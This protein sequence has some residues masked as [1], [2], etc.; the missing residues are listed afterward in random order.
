MIQKETSIKVILPRDSY[1]YCSTMQLFP[2]EFSKITFHPGITQSVTVPQC[3]KE[4]HR[5]EKHTKENCSKEKL[6]Q[7][8][9]APR[10]NATRENAL[11]KNASSNLEI[12]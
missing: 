1:C 2:R 7:G 3:S 6:S 12:K 4:K 9:T 10:K 11:R 8:K 5:K